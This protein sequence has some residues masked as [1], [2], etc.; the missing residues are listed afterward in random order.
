MALIRL[1][2]IC[3]TYHLGEIDVP[4]LR[5]IS[6]TIEQ[7]E[8]VGPDG[9]FR[10]RQDH[11]DEHSRLPRP[12]HFRPILARRPGDEPAFAEPA[13]ADPHGK[14]RLRLPELQSAAAHHGAAERADAP[15]LLP[16]DGF[17]AAKPA[18]GRGIALDPRRAGRADRPRAVADVGRSAAAGGDR[19]G[20]DQ[21]SARWSW[22]TSR[23]AIW[24]RRP[25]WRSWRC[26]SSS[27]P[28]E[29]R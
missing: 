22:P 7:G 6:L 16:R 2:N 27:T 21:S 8:M 24:T 3:K 10:L 15:G 19:P 23:P 4:V 5:G 29:S 12:A 9:R 25:A 26:S 17:P 13:G 18:A 28:R 11:A 1:E 20:A 14:A